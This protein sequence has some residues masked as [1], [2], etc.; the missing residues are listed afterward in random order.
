MFHTEDEG[1][2]DR[3]LK[4]LQACAQKVNPNS[5]VF[6]QRACANLYHDLLGDWKDWKEVTRIKNADA[7]PAL[8]ERIKKLLYWEKEG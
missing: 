6:Y 2:R 5:K 4:G 7:R 3:L 8:L 1:E